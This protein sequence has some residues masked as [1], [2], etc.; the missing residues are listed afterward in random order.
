MSLLLAGEAESNADGD[1]ALAIE[2][3]PSALANS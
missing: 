3:L 2:K 1:L